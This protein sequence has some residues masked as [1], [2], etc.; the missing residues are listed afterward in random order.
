MNGPDQRSDPAAGAAPRCEA[1][2]SARPTELA[3]PSRLRPGVIAAALLAACGVWLYG[4]VLSFE[5][6]GYD[7]YPMLESARIKTWS[8]LAGIFTLPLM[9]GEYFGAGFFRPV[10]DLFY[11]LGYALAG[12][13]PIGQHI[14]TLGVFAASIAMMWHALRRMLGGAGCDVWAGPLLG[15]LLYILHPAQIAIVPVSNQ[16]HDLLA[17]FFLL[18]ALAVLPVEG[19]RRR[20]WRLLAAGALSWAAAGSKEMGVIAVGLVFLHQLFLAPARD[21][22]H[23]VGWTILAVMP[24]LIGVGLFLWNRTA[25]LGGLAGYGTHTRLLEQT[26]QFAPILTGYTL[27]PIHSTEP[28]RS[29]EALIAGAFIAFIALLA[30]VP[31]GAGGGALRRIGLVTL[32]VTW[33]ATNLLLDG[34]SF[35]PYFRYAMV[36]SVGTAFILAAGAQRCTG[37]LRGGWP[38]RVAACV[39]AAGLGLPVYYQLR[40]SPAW[41]DYP[42]YRQASQ[43]QAAYLR[44]LAGRIEMA[45]PCETVREIVVSNIE[46]N[47]SRE[48][49]LL[50]HQ[51]VRAWARLNYPEKMNLGWR[52]GRTAYPTALP[53]AAIILELPMDGAYVGFDAA[54]R[55]ELPPAPPIFSVAAPVK[56]AASA[57][58]AVRPRVPL[59]PRRKS[60]RE[61]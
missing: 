11:A 27:N 45:R 7:G 2:P 34:L 55:C 26:R 57:P 1:P 4:E 10:H 59:G 42:E 3:G 8:D 37:W 14:V 6:I 35:V 21:L 13:A 19:D 25:V 46:P 24:A 52:E 12:P 53:P 49:T 54:G 58:S 16:R 61:R 33:C 44:R 39:A 28:G 20:A 48:A 9:R 17:V 36:L 29:A 18:A 47:R 40:E 22:L 43:M 50:Q 32:G 23:R 51:G 56:P 30:C 60:V 38:A 41:S 5:L 31:G 15:T